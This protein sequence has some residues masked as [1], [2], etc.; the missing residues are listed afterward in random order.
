M[1]AWNYSPWDNDDAA[2]WFQQFWKQKDFTLLIGEIKAF[3]PKEP[4]YDTFR[5][6]CYLLQTLG[7]PYVWPAEHLDELKS[8]IG[9]AI[10]IL[11]KMIN[12]PSKQWYF[13]DIWEGADEIIKSVQVQIDALEAQLRELA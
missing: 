13:L 7:N 5:A 4:S 1:S 8:L 3:D 2:D 6:A 9:H 10:S 12:P 11:T